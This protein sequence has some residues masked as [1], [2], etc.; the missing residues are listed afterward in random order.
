MSFWSTSTTTRFCE[1]WC[2]SP[3]NGSGRALPTGPVV[4]RPSFGWI[5]RF[6]M[7]M[8]RDRPGLPQLEDTGCKQPVAHDGEDVALWNGVSYDTGCKQPVA[9]DHGQCL[10]EWCWKTRV[11]SNPWHTM[12]GTVTV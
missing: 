3:R 4:R 5:G 11:A 7:S 10:L 9:H 2:R 12:Y 8:D 6:R 1:G